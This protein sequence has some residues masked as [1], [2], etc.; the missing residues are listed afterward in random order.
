MERALGLL[1]ALRLL[2]QQRLL[3]NVLFKRLVCP[4]QQIHLES[5]SFDLA[6]EGGALEIED[7]RPFL[8]QMQVFSLVLA[9]VPIYLI[10]AVL[11]RLDVNLL[12]HSGPERVYRLDDVGIHP[13][14]VRVFRCTSTHSIWSA[15]LLHICILICLVH[16]AVILL[17]G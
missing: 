12:E 1:E 11:Q 4:M 5:L 16:T 7:L 15:T 6:D 13:N 2:L 9:S 8:V 10:P 3:L 17:F 14:D